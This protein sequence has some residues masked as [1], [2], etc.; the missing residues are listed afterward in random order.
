MT[1][2]QVESCT[3]LKAIV[4][5]HSLGLNTPESDIDEMGI[6]IEPIEEAIGL[7]APFE[8]FVRTGPDATREGPDLQI[9]SL[10]KFMRLAL[11]GN[12]TILALLFIP[13]DKLLTCDARASQL[14]DLIP[15]I[16]SKKAG[17]AFLGYM[18][19]QRQRLLGERGEKGVRR[20]D[21]EEKYGYDT[22]Y[23]MHILRLGVQG[24]ELLTT[25]RLTFPMAES[26]RAFL[27]G[28][29]H[30]ALPFNDVLTKAGELEQEV[31]DL[32]DGGSPLQEKPDAESVEKW[33]VQTYE[34]VWNAARKTKDIREDAE[35][36][37]RNS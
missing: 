27:L 2:D 24:V 7:N 17:N 6:C 31:K 32:L 1:R 8:Q 28:I 16:I 26:D 21:L 13:T 19:A 11:S 20:R 12:P 22:K 36:F 18:Q 4:G 30:G 37:G 23:A 5:S 25:G 9:Y 15:M 33:M 35:R 29:R 14:R 34:R 3:I 10:R